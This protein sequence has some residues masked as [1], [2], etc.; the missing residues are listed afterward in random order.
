MVNYLIR[1][2]L[3][4]L[5]V[6][7]LMFNGHINATWITQ[8]SGI[9][10]GLSSVYFVNSNVGWA[11]GQLGT[12]VKTN[13]AGGF[14][15]PQNSGTSVDIFR[16][17]FLNSQ[18]GWFCGVGGVIKKTTDGGSTWISQNLNTS[19]TLSDIC[20]IDQNT[21]YVCGGDFY[22]TTNSGANW[23]T[24]P[25]NGGTYIFFINSTTGYKTDGNNISK[26]T[27]QGTNFSLIN[28]SSYLLG[29]FNFPNYTTGY[30]PSYNGMY[31]K[32]TNGGDNWT[33]LSTGV[34]TNLT[35][36]SFP[37]A[38]TGVI[39]GWNGTVLRTTNGGNSWDAQSSGS[40]Y[41][42]QAVHFIDGKT[43]WTVGDNGTILHT[44]N[45]GVDVQNISSEIPNEFKLYQNYPNPFNPTT[46][47]KFQ[48][49]KN[50]SVILCVY[51]ILGKNIMTLVN[52]KLP[53]GEFEFSFDAGNL[54]SGIYFY[55][56]ETGNFSETKKMILIK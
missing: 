2:F 9:Q 3:I 4:Y 53:A 55:K 37:D 46:N 6:I 43:G 7:C 31:I 52:E 22:R 14:W 16:I 24:I 40:F 29:K 30:V 5:F 12:I 42:L 17:A 44:T 20:I 33:T 32:T 56:L 26:T 41:N 49:V 50:S 47:I 54:E 21:L 48:I 23:T 45:G 28:S 27:N 11:A 35:A 18:T 13:N 34:T 8:A 51:D 15:N 1:K 10:Y 39:V 38:S 36:S 19:N 25:G